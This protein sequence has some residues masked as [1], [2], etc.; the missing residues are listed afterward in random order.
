M[1][2]GQTT[3]HICQTGWAL[4]SW[5]W[6]GRAALLFPPQWLDAPLP[7]VPG[8]SYESKTAG[9]REG[10]FCRLSCSGFTRM[11]LTPPNMSSGFGSLLLWDSIPFPENPKDPTVYMVSETPSAFWRYFSCAVDDWTR[12]ITLILFLRAFLLR[13]VS[14]VKDYF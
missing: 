4:A 9:Q 7:P 1:G 8:D 11:A 14:V 6:E 13:R 3:S 2:A 12:L 5:V 10:P